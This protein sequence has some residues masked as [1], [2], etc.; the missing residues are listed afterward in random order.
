[1]RPSAPDFTT[2]CAVIGAGVVGLAIARRLAMAGRDVLILEAAG[3]IGQGI[4]SR[5]SEVLH[6]GIYY[7]TGSLR[8]R[9]CAPGRRALAA[10]ADAHGV[11]WRR[12]GKLLVA[13]TEAEI[14]RLEALAR[15]ADINGVE[16][17]A[18]LTGRQARQLEPALACVA[19]L[20]STQT[21][22][23][24]SHALMLSL[25]GEAQDHGASLALLSPLD[26]AQARQ[27]GFLLATGGAEPSRVQTQV[28][29][30]AAGLDACFVASRIDG[31]ADSHI[32]TPSLAKGSYFALRGKNPFSRLIY[33]VPIPGGAG[34]HLTLDM[35]G[36]A[37]FGPD[38]EPV[39]TR[40]TRVEPARA[41]LFAD[42]IRRYWPGLPDDALIP[43]YAG[44][45]PKIVPPT[46][47]Q[48][49]LIQDATAHGLPGLIN[50]FGIESP[51]LTSCLAI[52][53][54]VAGLLA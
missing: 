1:L 25:L 20:H 39:T 51:G 12:C 23:I 52:A 45:R 9:L 32:P 27:D 48:D 34:I 37:R 28:L 50:L 42:A 44:L 36:H 10:Y 49:F 31:L 2:G 3:A 29:I 43:A 8:A 13:T 15:Q 40:D 47:T 16:G 53:D 19:A 24:D 7:A 35:A 54:H 21:G 46:E 33:P 17:M 6:A 4:S 14:P 41:G 22:I 26:H 30:N 11:H 18:P 5:S 38:V